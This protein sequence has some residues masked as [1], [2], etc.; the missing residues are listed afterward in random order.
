[1]SAKPN[2]ESL[3]VND[4]ELLSRFSATGDQQA[5]SQLVARHGPMVLRM[6]RRIFQS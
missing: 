5:F 6:C 3:S 2:G 1:M 4:G